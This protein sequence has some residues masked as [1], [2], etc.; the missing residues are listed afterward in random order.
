MAEILAASFH[1]NE[2]WGRWVLPLMQMG[3]YEDLRHRL[4]SPQSRYAGLVAA[5]PASTRPEEVVGTVEISLKSYPMP[6][7]Q[8]Q[9]VQY[10][11]VSNLA[12]RAEARR[13]GVARKLL[14]A[15][16]EQAQLWGFQDLYLHVLENNQAARSLYSSLGYRVRRF[17]STWGSLWFGQPRQLFLHK[18]LK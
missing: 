6:L 17:D 18:R 8:L 16:E 10:P 4:R 2:G 13:C 14:I 15:C 3:I 11:Y 7:W 1:D 12:V 5:P 9:G